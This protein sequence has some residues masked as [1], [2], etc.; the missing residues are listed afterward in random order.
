MADHKP[1]PS[2]ARFSIQIR[3]GQGYYIADP[4]GVAVSCIIKGQDQA[5]MC[6]DAKQAAYDLKRKRIARP[7]MCCKRQFA[8]EGIH[9]RLC[10]PCRAKSHE[11]A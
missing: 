2:R 4:D 1:K 8:S 3:V 6:L 11:F 9:N 10:D 5:Q 7:C